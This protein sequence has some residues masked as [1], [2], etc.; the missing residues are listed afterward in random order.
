MFL[1]YFYGILVTLLLSY[2][3]IEKKK[4]LF[5]KEIN[6]IRCQEAY[7]IEIPV[8]IQTFS[9]LMR[10]KIIPSNKKNKSVLFEYRR[11]LYAAMPLGKK[12]I[13]ISKAKG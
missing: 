13:L 2:L 10:K 5:Y 6:Q 7:S 1:I 11:M 4:L 9:Q 8:S 12:N 3:V